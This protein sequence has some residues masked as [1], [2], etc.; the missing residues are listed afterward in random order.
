MITNLPTIRS[1]HFRNTHKA[2]VFAILGDQTPRVEAKGSRFY[3]IDRWTVRFLTGEVCQW[4]KKNPGT[5]PTR[6]DVSAWVT[7]ANSKQVPASSREIVTAAIPN[8]LTVRVAMSLIGGGYH[9]A[10]HTKYSCRRSL[11]VDEVSSIILPRWAKVADWSKLEKMLQEW[12]NVV[13]DIRIE[14]RGNEEY[15]GAYIKMC[16]LQDFILDQEAAG[17]LDME[18]AGKGA[19]I[20]KPLGIAMMA[21]RDIGLGYPTIK[22]KAAL[23]LYDTLNPETMKLVC[24]GALSGFLD[25]AIALSAKDD[26]GCLRLSFDIVAQLAQLADPKDLEQAQDQ[27]QD[28]KQGPKPACPK[29]GAKG[30]KLVARPVSDGMGGKKPG[31]LVI[32]CTV[33]GWQEEVDTKPPGSAKPQKQ[34]PEDQI[35]Y[36]DMPKEDSPKS[37]GSD[38]DGSDPKQPGEKDGSKGEKGDSGDSDSDESGDSDSDESGGGKSDS[39]KPGKGD[40]AGSKGQSDS[41]KPS[42]SKS[43]SKGAGGHRHNAGKVD[44]KALADL[45]KELLAGKETGM[46]D[47]S[48]ALE[49]AIGTV[50]KAEDNSCKTGEKPYRPFQTIKD[51]TKLV[52]AS[53]RGKSDD[54]ARAAAMMDS[55][56]AESSYMRSRL[57]SLVR[58]VEQQD[59]VHGVKKGRDLSERMLVDSYAM[60]E[61][62]QNPD[63]AYQEIDAEIDTSMAAVL[64]IDQSSSMCGPKQIGAAKGMMAVCDPL[65]SL[66]CQTMAVG[67]R[68]GAYSAPTTDMVSHGG[69][70]HRYTSL[71]YDIFKNFNEKFS[72]AKWRF[73][74]VRAEGGT[75]MADGVQFG[76]DQLNTRKEGHRVL[77][78]FTDGEPNGGHREV[79]RHQIRL[80]TEAGIKVIGVGIGSGSEY[81]QNVFPDSV[82]A[83]NFSDLPKLLMVK[84]TEMMDFRTSVHK[85]GKT[86]RKA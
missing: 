32:T 26:L 1:D 30:S 38:K 82:Y 56:R 37:N 14:R 35:K 63:R 68:D 18:K 81:V 28:S 76:L 44:P 23:D 59:I 22:Q 10:F 71:R 21:F 25:E 70:Y 75:P 85:R 54:V 64:V 41:D 24:E 66:G 13:E 29:C 9:E 16:D 42:D 45:V 12:N 69:N 79:M 46:K 11:T 48:T 51:E 6:N 4:A 67:F 8:E 62:G 36:E 52:E 2:S 61:N 86:M 55:V 5:C 7:V 77:F 78:V 80:A 84:L 3:N 34:D 74:N 65:D 33:C 53:N 49:Q 73:A 27:A 17:R 20:K 50:R 83:A 39:D 47:A 57:R 58:S 72:T 15:P 19:E 40:G 31:K 60:M 43:P